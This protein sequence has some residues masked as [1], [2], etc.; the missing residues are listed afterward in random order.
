MG[1][2]E[3]L[4]A[5]DGEFNIFVKHAR[6]AEEFLSDKLSPNV[7]QIV[8]VAAVLHMQAGRPLILTEIR[9]RDAGP[10][11]AGR[12]ADFRSKHLPDAIAENM[13][14]ILNRWFPY[15]DGVHDTIPPINHVGTYSKSTAPHFHVQV[16]RF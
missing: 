9:R 7:R 1:G 16:R 4:D 10:H 8:R 6:L 12:A 14:E 5:I 15:G 13:R 3:Q 11:G 2:G